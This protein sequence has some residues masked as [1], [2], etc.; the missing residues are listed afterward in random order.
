MGRKMTLAKVAQHVNDFGMKP[1]KGKLKGGDIHSSGM[2]LENSTLYERSQSW[3]PPWI[4]SKF[5][6]LN[7][8]LPSPTSSVRTL[9]FVVSN[10]GYVWAE[11]NHTTWGLVLKCKIMYIAFCIILYGVWF[12]TVH[13]LHHSLWLKCKTDGGR[14]MANLQFQWV[15]DDDH[16]QYKIWY[17][18]TASDDIHW[19]SKEYTKGQYFWSE[20]KYLYWSA[21][22]GGNSLLEVCQT[23]E[24]DI[25]AS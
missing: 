6:I 24:H 16:D 21:A 9:A 10:T 12:C 4:F 8:Y 5:V 23:I 14:E 17:I 2:T 11:W 7:P 13:I 3:Y 20:K 18:R 15:S 25:P 19:I 22:K 1:V